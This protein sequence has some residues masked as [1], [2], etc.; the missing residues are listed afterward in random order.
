MNQHSNGISRPWGLSRSRPF[1]AFDPA[2]APVTF[3]VD[4]DPVTQTGVY[5]DRESGQIIEAGKHGTNKETVNKLKTSGGD[6]SKDGGSDV[7]STPD[8][9]TD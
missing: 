7:V 5:R 4:L 1:P 8:Y 9:D 2:A 3:R 6:G